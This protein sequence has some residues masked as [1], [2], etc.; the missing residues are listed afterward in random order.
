MFNDNVLVEQPLSHT[1][2]TNNFCQ[3]GKTISINYVLDVWRRRWWR[4]IDLSLPIR[5]PLP[6]SPER[7]YFQY[8]GNLESWSKPRLGLGKSLH[9][10][11]VTKSRLSLVARLERGLAVL[12]AGLKR[13]VFEVVK[14]AGVGAG[15]LLQGAFGLVLGALGVWLRALALLAGLAVVM[16]LGWELVAHREGAFENTEGLLGLLSTVFEDF[17]AFLE[18]IPLFSGLFAGSSAIATLRFV[19]SFLRLLRRLLRGV[20]GT[21]DRLG[22]FGV[23]ISLVARFVL[24]FAI[25]GALFGGRLALFCRFFSFW[26][27]GGLAVFGIGGDQG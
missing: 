25:F 23:R 12:L 7:P 11:N 22:G 10:E 19:L 4:T 13:R 5:P 27:G 9:I 24:R 20:F 2:K 26:R 3:I 15:A 1:D 14:R 17:R 18:K 8:S 21:F 6:R 16:G